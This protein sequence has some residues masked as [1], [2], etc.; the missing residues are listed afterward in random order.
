MKYSFLLILLFS[1]NAFS[2]LS[3]E[4]ATSPELLTSVRAL[5]M[6]NSYAS[7]VDDSTAA[8]YNPAGLGTV[9]GGLRLHL[10]N[11]Q[12]EMNR[13]FLDVTSGKGNFLDS[14]DKY[15]DAFSSDGVRSL[16]ADNPGN[17][18]HAK[19][20]L[21]PNI[22]YRWITLGYLYNKEQRARLKTSTSDFEIA[23]RE[24]SGPVLSLA[25]S[26]FG[27]VFKIG[28]TLTHLTRKEIFRDTAENDT[29]NISESDYSQGELNH[30]VAGTRMTFPVFLLPTISFVGR[31]LG[32]NQWTNISLAGAP[33]DIPETFDA[34]VSITPFTGRRSRL[35]IEIGRKDLGD[36]YADV[37][38]AR[39]LQG[40]IEWGYGRKY[41]FR[42]GYGD[43]WGSGGTGVRSR[44][45][46][47]DLSTYA[48]EGSADKFREEEDRRF[49]LNI[50]SGVGF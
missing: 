23:E 26:L 5:G 10:T 46:V 42:L 14:L 19:F 32:S 36:Q 4:D 45:F 47:F 35:H 9:R 16:L 22:T 37:P 33:E 13:G 7:L 48:V 27:G 3:F 17:I 11:F 6:G 25:F 49:A 44:R 28:A 31:N 43:G 15:D 20:S 40:G 50:S 1:T 30:I 39:K 24:S 21:F 8:F 18:T 12:L 41:F 34:S 38:I 2:K 29:L